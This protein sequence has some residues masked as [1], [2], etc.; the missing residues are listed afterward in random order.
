MRKWTSVLL[1]VVALGGGSL[2]AVEISNLS[3]QSCGDF[4]G[5]WHFVNN[6][7]GRRPARN[8]TATWSSGDTCTVGAIEGP[9]KHAALRLHCVG[10]T[11]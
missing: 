3:G 8:I 1:A 7:T 5:N 10:H 11:A 4:S 2:M 6:Q 9:R